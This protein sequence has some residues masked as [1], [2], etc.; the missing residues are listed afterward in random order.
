MTASVRL[1]GLATP[2]TTATDAGIDVLRQ[3]GSVIDAALTAAITLTVVYPHNTGVGGDLIALLRRPDGQIHC[4]NASGPAPAATDRDDIARRH[5]GRM[6]T[7]GADTITVPGAVAGWR[8]LHELGGHL[9]WARLFEPAIAAADNGVAVSRSLAGALDDL[10]DEIDPGLAGVFRP[11]GKTPRLGEHVVQPRLA[12]T[13]RALARDGADAMYDGAVGVALAEG[14]HA[15]GCRL[16][17]EDL[18][19]FEPEQP[20][21]LS[22]DFAD[23]RVWT[24]PPN[25]QGVLL[26]EILGAIDRLP[27]D[28]RDLLAGDAD[29]LAAL[30]DQANHDRMAHVADPRHQPVDVAALLDDARLGSLAAAA[31]TGEA[32]P[33]AATTGRATGDT[34]AV[35]AMADD[36][37]SVSLIQS[38]FHS[39]GSGILEPTTGI[40]L[41]NRG[42]FFS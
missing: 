12:T 35:T 6:P 36:G 8:R 38:L 9:P 20:A 18:R 41:H 15:V 21:P 37:T 34:I 1:A 28:R 26:L 24:A 23:Q 32:E 42:S 13:L 39:F 14:L 16:T 30:F 31:A 2:H 29:V 7:Y 40:V 22:I 33:G 10:P 4:I 11:D 25:S 5:N 17:I 3:G 27:T 19:N